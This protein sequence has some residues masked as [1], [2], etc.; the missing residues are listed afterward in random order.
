MY[1]VLYWFLLF[2]Q[3]MIRYI[4]SG[5]KELVLRSSCPLDR[6]LLFHGRD[7]ATIAF[8]RST[9]E[10]NLQRAKQLMALAAESKLVYR[11]ANGSQAAARTAA[12]AAVVVVSGGPQKAAS[13]HLHQCNA[14]GVCIVPAASSHDHDVTVGG[15]HSSSCES[16]V[17]A[18]LGTAGSNLQ[19]IADTSLP[20]EE[21]RAMA[22]K[23]ERNR[24]ELL[25]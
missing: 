3:T 5:K 17:A 15:N 1:E 9:F 12:A 4:H 7:E 23:L 13:F 25:G 22:K 24:L 14:T 10:S 6:E 11:Y 2:L 8:L 19:W 16:E 18:A 21:V 20:R